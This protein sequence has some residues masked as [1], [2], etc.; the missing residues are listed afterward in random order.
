MWVNEHFR[1]DGWF[2]DY[3]CSSGIRTRYTSGTLKESSY[4]NLAC[5][6]NYRCHAKNSDGTL[7]SEYSSMQSFWQRSA[8]Y[9][10]LMNTHS[11]K[12][13][14]VLS[15]NFIH[16]RSIIK[17]YQI[18][19]QHSALTPNSGLAQMTKLSKNHNFGSF[20]ESSCAPWWIQK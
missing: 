2:Y 13:S 12:T 3:C 9:A 8:G 7:K 5:V 14:R 10:S 20:T 19:Q 16:L 11:L 17:I 4:Q 15:G 6:M 1:K 18:F